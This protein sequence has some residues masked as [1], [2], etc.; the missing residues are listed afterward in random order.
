MQGCSLVS[1]KLT[2][3]LLLG[4]DLISPE[5]M[6]LL[7]SSD[8]TLLA[9]PIMALSRP[10]RGATSMSNPAA[11][12]TTRALTFAFTLV[13]HDGAQVASQQFL[14]GR[15]C[16]LHIASCCLGALDVRAVQ[17]STAPAVR[18]EQATRGLGTR[19]TRA[20]VL[21]AAL[22]RM[23]SSMQRV[24]ANMRSHWVH[25]RPRQLSRSP[26]SRPPYTYRTPFK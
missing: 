26:A 17:D 10:S 22:E 12:P 11:A 1:S 2:W 6:V 9:A 24:W 23:R 20:Y 15:I 18:D 25:T 8:C 13:A 3:K 19:V 14:I 5:G 7:M 16:L 4:N 21:S